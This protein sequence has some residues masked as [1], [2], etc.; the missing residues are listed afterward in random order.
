MQTNLCEWV[1]YSCVL[2]FRWVYTYV[3][4]IIIWTCKVSNSWSRAIINI[5]WWLPVPSINNNNKFTNSKKIY[6]RRSA[7]SALFFHLKIRQWWGNFFC[8][9]HFVNVVFY[10]WYKSNSFLD[11][12]ALAILLLSDG[13]HDRF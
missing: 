8:L 6:T 7:V 10:T 1:A 11:F 12:Y 4:I 9:L 5:V 2:L 13:L 3:D